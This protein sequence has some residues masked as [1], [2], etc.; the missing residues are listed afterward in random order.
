MGFWRFDQIISGNYKSKTFLQNGK[1]LN[2]FSNE[3]QYV[4]GMTRERYANVAWIPIDT[5]KSSRILN[6]E[7][8]IRI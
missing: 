6:A 5:S 1:F 7:Y 8:S 3:C 4:A 2:G